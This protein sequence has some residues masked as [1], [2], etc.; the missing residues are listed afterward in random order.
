MDL[1]SELSFKELQELIEKIKNN[2]K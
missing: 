2:R 1:L